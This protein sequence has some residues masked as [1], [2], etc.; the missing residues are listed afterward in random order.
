MF[1]GIID[2]IGTGVDRTPMFIEACAI[3]VDTVVDVSAVVLWMSYT[4]D[5]RALKGDRTLFVAGISIDLRTEVLIDVLAGMVTGIT[6]G[7]SADV[8]AGADGST[9]AVM[10]AL[11]FMPMLTPPDEALPFGWESCSCWPTAI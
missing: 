7:I 2:I 10:T 5:R 11:E 9:L 4:L 3:P 6:A 8:L 1:G